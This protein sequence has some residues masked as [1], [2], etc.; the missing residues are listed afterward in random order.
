[1]SHRFVSLFAATASLCAPSLVVAQSAA[2]HVRA[3]HSLAYDEARQRVILTG[4]ST[5]LDGGRNFRFFND[6]WEFDGARWSALPSSGANLSGT[7]LAYDAKGKRI[8][9]FGGYTGTASIGDLR[10]LENNTWRTIGQHPEISAAEPGFVYDIKRG[11]FIAFGGSGG[12]GR[13]NG[14][15]WT[16][17]GER[18]MRLATTNPPPR[19]AHAM[20]Y[21]ERRGVTV[22]F[23]GMGS[24]A[25]NGPPPM[26]G[27]LWEFDG[28]AWTQVNA[29]GPSPRN[30]PGMAYDSKRGR[31]ILFGGADS[32]GF[33]G[34]TWSW[35]GAVWRKLAETGPDPRGMGY[36]A[37]DKR[38]DRVVLFGGR[39]GW[40][41]GDLNDSWEWD[42][43]A[44]RRVGQ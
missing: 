25:A 41:N 4:G 44:W 9:S 11:H 32:G 21:D 34:D 39:K 43:S 13:T 33:K 24:R 10:V 16:F 22:L 17:D 19:Q 38:R 2:P 8:V 20:V 14:D 37:Y 36:L 7:R 42:G 29:T 15:T 35:D 3:H 23:G 28:N 26:L 30:S 27:D 1:M 40:P 31:V 6:L 5:P 18:W 12:Q